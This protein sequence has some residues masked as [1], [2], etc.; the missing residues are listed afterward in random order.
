MVGDCRGGHG[1]NYRIECRITSGSQLTQQ[2]ALRVQVIDV[3]IVAH[4]TFKLGGGLLDR[5][6]IFAPHR[7]GNGL[8]GMMP[9]RRVSPFFG[10]APVNEAEH[11]L[12]R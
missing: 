9:V 1:W 11:L 5:G 12:Q 6:R 2:S 4:R 10:Q 7:S 3:V 8:P